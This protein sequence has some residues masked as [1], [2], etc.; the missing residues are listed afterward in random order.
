MALSNKAVA[1]VL[2]A[3]S[4]IAAS[5]SIGWLSLNSLV[6]EERAGAGMTWEGFGLRLELDVALEERTLIIEMAVKNLASEPVALVFRTS[7]MWDT[8]VR[9]AEGHVLWR[10]SA[11]KVFLQAVQYRELAPGEDMTFQAKWEAPGNG[12]Y[13]VVGYFLGHIGDLSGPR[14]PPLVHHVEIS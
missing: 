13:E 12:R 10:W 7:Q 5:V 2:M 8:E 4:L 3:I 14:P 9:D 11:D 1:L 6:G